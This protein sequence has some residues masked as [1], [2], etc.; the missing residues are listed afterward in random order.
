MSG[1]HFIA[2]LTELMQ[3]SWK[4]GLCVCVCV[5]VCVSSG[6][7]E[8]LAEVFIASKV[9]VEWSIYGMRTSH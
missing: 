2:F 4:I 1:L 7:W 8:G 3:N 9:K 6:N 5:C